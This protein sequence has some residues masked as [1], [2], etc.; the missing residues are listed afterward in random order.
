MRKLLVGVCG[1]FL[2]PVLG[3]ISASAQSNETVFYFAEGTT[4][5]GFYETIWVLNTGPDGITVEIEY[6][7]SD[8]TPLVSK[9][10]SIPARSTRGI[11]P[12]DDEEVG[13]DRDFALVLRSNERF[14]AARSIDVSG[15]TFNDVADVVGGTTMAGIPATGTDFSLA[16]G[17]TLPGFQEYITIENPSTEAAPVSITYGLE[18]HAGRTTSRTLAPHTRATVDVN[19]A[20]GARP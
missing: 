15:H 10:Y 9:E 13:P 8:G 5:P 1:L 18:G 12:G 17:S 2:V 3:P 6:D 4:R 19:S 7:F 20:G 11:V 14:S 16:E